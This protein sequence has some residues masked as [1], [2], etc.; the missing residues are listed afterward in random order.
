MWRDRSG[1]LHT[2]SWPDPAD[3]LGPALSLVDDEA[4]ATGFERFAVEVEGMQNLLVAELLVEDWSASEEADYEDELLPP[5][6]IAEAMREDPD[7]VAEL[8][9]GVPLRWR[10]DVLLA[11][12]DRVD[13]LAETQ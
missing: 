7:S 8:V 1:I 3:T 12:A 13:V 2:G 4:L 11:V 5:V 9:V 6:V 10:L